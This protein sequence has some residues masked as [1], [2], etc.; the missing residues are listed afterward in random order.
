M[1]LFDVL[2][3][4][5]RPS[6]LETVS[7]LLDRPPSP[8]LSAAIE[9]TARVLTQ[10]RLGSGLASLRPRLILVFARQSADAAE[11]MASSYWTSDRGVN[12]GHDVFRAHQTALNTFLKVIDKRP[13][14]RSALLDAVTAI[15][16]LIPAWRNAPGDA[17]GY[18]IGTLHEI[19]R[20]LAAL[21]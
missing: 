1:G 18:G 8:R 10:R 15:D 11:K 7:A 16:A 19:R 2:P 21:L 13:Q 20:D 17:D 9:E 3:W 12:V 14:S 5:R 6:D 4:K